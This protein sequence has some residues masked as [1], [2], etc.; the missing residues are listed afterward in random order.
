MVN[1]DLNDEDEVHRRAMFMYNQAREGERSRHRARQGG[2]LVYR[3]GGEFSY[4]LDSARSVLHGRLIRSANG[5][6]SITPT[7]P[8]ITRSTAL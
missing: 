8:R 6:C 7:K 4:W 2:P 5:V 1:L 3:Q